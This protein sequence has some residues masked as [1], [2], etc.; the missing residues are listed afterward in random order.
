MYQY[1]HSLSVL[2]LFSMVVLVLQ[3]TVVE[4]GTSVA[5][6]DNLFEGQTYYFRVA[7]ENQAGRG[8]YGETSA[9]AVAK[10]PYGRPSCP[11]DVTVTEVWKDFVRI[12]WA[13]PESDGGVPLSGYNIEQRDAYE[14]S[15]RYQGG[16][17]Q[18]YA[19]IVAY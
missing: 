16:C 17:T 5:R 2:T 3:A 6:V 12:S 1:K 15:Y 18:S 13:A 7:A 10:L 11:R 8:S 19:H 14:G 9:G 4:P